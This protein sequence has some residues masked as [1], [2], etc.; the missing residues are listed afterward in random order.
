MDTLQIKTFYLHETLSE[1]QI[2]N[3]ETSNNV[4]V[5]NSLFQ[6]IMN[7]RQDNQNETKMLILG[8]YYKNKKIYVNIDGSHHNEN[9]IIYTPL[10]VY[11]YLNYIDG[12]EINYMQVYPHTGS[13]IKI[14]PHSDFYAYLPDPVQSL[15]NG[16][17]HYSI[18]M[19]NTT[20]PLNI[21]GQTLLIDIID[22]YSQNKPINIRGIELEV[23]I[24]EIGQV[25]DQEIGQ[26]TDQKSNIGIFQHIVEEKIDFSSMISLPITD[27]RFPGVGRRLG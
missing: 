18:L 3:Y 15:R 16:F 7:S 14:K 9:N 19:P 27:N 2:N 8:L 5:S 21:D 13:K 22:T 20:I 6:E 25:T 24:E 11:Q 1:D 12:D 26:E 10:W 23:D 17:E 4:L